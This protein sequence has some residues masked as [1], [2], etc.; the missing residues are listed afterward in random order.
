MTHSVS[1]L[2]KKRG[3]TELVAFVALIIVAFSISVFVYSY[4]ELQA[5]KDRP[6]CPEGV[7]LVVSDAACKMIF[8]KSGSI[9]T[10]DITLE[11]KGRRSIDGAYIRMGTKN[12]NVKELLN[13]DKLYFVSIS[14]SEEGR[15]LQPGEKVTQSYR[16]ELLISRAGEYALEVQPFIGNPGSLALCENAVVTRT[17]PCEFELLPG[18]VP[19]SIGG[20]YEYPAKEAGPRKNFI[21]YNKVKATVTSQPPFADYIDHFEAI[22]YERSGSNWDQKGKLQTETLDKGVYSIMFGSLQSASNY[23]IEA[24]IYVYN[25]DKLEK[26]PVSSGGSNSREFTV[27]KI[28]YTCDSSGGVVV[29]RYT[30]GRSEIKYSNR[31]GGNRL[32]Y[33]YC[34][35]QGVYEPMADSE[36]VDFDSYSCYPGTCETETGYL[37]DQSYPYGACR[38]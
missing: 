27:P 30:D 36:V 29:Y 19:A 32:F 16:N 7:S 22:L 5:P 35:Y 34:W 17:I 13:K 24:F 1:L 38:A 12:Q 28:K 21:Y 4:L 15:T 14:S 2:L 26:I 11:N 37:N 9:S 18:G 25:G 8:R 23:K 10:L 3:V 20:T 6:Q 31:C 33:F